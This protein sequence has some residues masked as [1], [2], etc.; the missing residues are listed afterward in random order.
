MGKNG[1]LILARWAEDVRICYCCSRAVTSPRVLSRRRHRLVAGEL[2]GGSRVGIP[3][4]D[5]N[6]LDGDLLWTYA[7]LPCSRQLALAASVGATQH[8]ILA[9]LHELACSLLVLC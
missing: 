8:E 6:I 5:Q 4:K 1:R 3:M 2:G 7:H 9:S